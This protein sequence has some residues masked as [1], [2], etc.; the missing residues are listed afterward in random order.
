MWINYSEFENLELSQLK[1]FFIEKLDSDSNNLCNLKISDL[2]FNGDRLMIE[3]G[4]GVYIFYNS[5]GNRFLYVGKCS[6]RHFVERISSHFDPR[7]NGWFNSLLK[8]LI[9]N[10]INQSNHDKQALISAKLNEIFAINGTYK[11]CL[12]FVPDHFDPKRISKLET[13]LRVVLNPLN[14]KRG[15]FDKGE[16]L[17]NL[18]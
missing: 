3:D 12:L 7:L 1:K 17:N 15:G 6:S 2:I 18:I 11:L 16:R 10:E 13:V 4:R 14:N 9:K 5:K 8:T